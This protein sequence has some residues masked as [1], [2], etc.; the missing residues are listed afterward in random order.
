MRIS[1]DASCGGKDTQEQRLG[2]RGT[3]RSVHDLAQRRTG[4]THTRRSL[5]PTLAL[6]LSAI[7]LFAAAPAAAQSAPTGKPL[8]THAYLIHLGYEVRWQ[9]VLDDDTNS[10]REASVT[11]YDIQYRAMG[12]TSW[13]D[14]SH[15]GTSWTVRITGLTIGTEYQVRVRKTNAAGNGPWSDIEDADAVVSRS[16]IDPPVG[17]RVTPGNAKATFTWGVPTHTSGRTITGYDIF[18]RGAAPGSTFSKTVIV[19]GAT[20][21]SGEVTG[22]TNGTEYEGYV[23]ARSLEGG[24]HTT[25]WL[26]FT[27]RASTRRVSFAQST[28]SVIEGASVTLTVNVSPAL[29]TASSVNVVMTNRRTTAASSDYSVTGLTGISLTLAANAT[30]ATFTLAATSDTNTEDPEK[31]EY[32]LEAIQNAD[33]VVT[34]SGDTALVTISDPPSTVA[35]LS[36]LAASTSAS[37]TG[38][39]TSLNIGTFAS[40]TTSYMAT[41][42]NSVT[43]AKLTPA[44]TD[45]DATVKVGVG[46]SLTTVT[47][48]SASSAIALSVGSNALKVVV[49]AEDGT[50]MQTYTVTVTRQAS[51]VATLSGLT[52][53]TSTSATGSF[54]SL[55]IGTFATSTT[56]YTATVANSVTHAKLTPTLTDSDATVKVGVG[57][58]LTAV[59]SG[60]AS[61]AIALSVGSNAIKAVVTAEDGMTMQTYT[62]TVTRQPSTVAT[63]SGLTA[64]TSTS[65]T[66]SFTSLNIGTFASGTTSYTATVANSVTHAK[67]TP[68]VTHSAA[69]VMVGKGSSLTTVASGS[70]SGAIALSVGSNAIKAVVTAEDGTTTQTYTVTVTRQASTVATLSGLTASTSMSATGTFTSLNIGTFAASTTSYTAS[71][72]NSV[73]HLKL[74]PTVADSDATVKV[75]K[76]SSLTTVTSG[77]ASVAI[78]LLVGSNAIKAVVTAED[79]TTTQTYTVTVTRH[80]IPTVSL[81]AAPIRVV[82]GASVTVTAMLSRALSSAVTIPVTVSTASPNTAESSD[83]GTLTSIAIAAGQT[84][85]TG[86]ITTNHDSGKDDETFTVSLGTSLPSSV[87]AGTPASVTV[88]IA[89]D[90]TNVA[91]S[92]SSAEMTLCE[93]GPKKYLPELVLS[94]RPD[95]SYAAIWLTGDAGTSEHRDHDWHY[96]AVISLQRRT[97]FVQQN[98][99]AIRA[100]PDADSDFEEFTVEINESKIPAGFVARQP[101]EGDGDDHRRRHMGP[102]RLR[103]TTGAAFGHRRPGVRAGRRLDRLHGV[104]G[105]QFAG[106]LHGRLPHRERYG[107]RRGGLQSNVGPADVPADSALPKGQSVPFRRQ[108][109]GRRRGDVQAGAAQPAGSGHRKGRRHRDHRGL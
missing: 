22:L 106:T 43:H 81:S 93:D 85:G 11:G 77:T 84:T 59:T 107:D 69:T 90:E 15:S 23:R 73:T 10:V 29:T 33:Y 65:A 70:A 2:V 80:T 64:S 19:S 99:Y 87:S 27:P 31:V 103:H 41:V 74:T 32:V 45:T 25:P 24:A 86:T 36:S 48:G 94:R 78:A 53:S 96:S 34:G 8:I 58:S 60:S 13:T 105:P 89:D 47:S 16:G 40:G 66:G 108:R 5:V 76:G 97:H 68:T 3:E 21:T 20:T 101:A 9:D 39:F 75:G 49:T 51:T 1:K 104:G 71:V 18:V 55:S 92:F 44:L 17:A 6:M 95:T 7:A 88:T 35:T 37:S 109:A 28:Y 91:V 56:S 52:A 63:L 30:T 12:T 100:L 38:T 102:G 46:T 61:G 83:I 79:G 62:V 82:E 14:V 50:T 98:P 67:L 54:T 42:A 26:T 4:V 57:T 72:D